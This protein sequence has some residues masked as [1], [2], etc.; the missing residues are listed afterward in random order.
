M[1]HNCV[2]C[3]EKKKKKTLLFTLINGTTVAVDINIR[4]R[5][6]SVTVK[7]EVKAFPHSKKFT[8]W[9]SKTITRKWSQT[10]N[11]RKLKGSA[12][13]KQDKEQ[14]MWLRV[15]SKL[16]QEFHVVFITV[17]LDINFQF[18][19]QRMQFLFSYF[20]QLTLHTFRPWLGHHQGYIDKFTSLFTT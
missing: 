5:S 17:H 8:E 6:I 3:D 16:V 19:N 1:Y 4:S 10:Q 9:T 15:S 14:A 18:F 13:R 12:L 20:V 7:I 11:L 2:S